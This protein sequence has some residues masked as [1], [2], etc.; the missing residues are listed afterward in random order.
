MLGLLGTASVAGCLRLEGGAETSTTGDDSVTARTTD[1]DS[2]TGDDSTTTEQLGESDTTTERPE[3]ASYPVGLSDDGVSQFLFDAH[4]RALTGTSCRTSWRKLNHTQGSIDWERTYEIDSGDAVGA[5]TTSEGGTVSMFRSGSDGYWREELGDTV[6][7]GEDEEGFSWRRVSWG[8][9]IAPSLA[10]FDW[11]APERVNE[12][13]PAVWEVS[14]TAIADASSSP[15]YIPGTVTSLEEATMR[16]NEDG[17]IVSFHSTYTVEEDGREGETLTYE[18]SFRTEAVGEVSVAAP[19]WVS[20]ARERVPVVSASFASDPG[21]VEITVES[22]GPLVADSRLVLVPESGPS[23]RREVELDE[24]IE[25]GTTVYVWHEEGDPF[26]EARLS[27]G[28]PPT[29]ASPSSLPDALE[30]YMYRDARVYAPPKT[31]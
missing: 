22:G 14:T 9:E 2:A 21:I 8:V 30:L 16:V 10:A 7:Y 6:V 24:P 26:R 29:G 5:W 23:D 25:S 3:E 20:T 13:R 11:G 17:V 12:N 1:P 28:S 4:T 31:V 19:S 18:S 15:G 27:R